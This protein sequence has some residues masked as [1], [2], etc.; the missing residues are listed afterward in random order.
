MYVRL[1]GYMTRIDVLRQHEIN[2]VKGNTTFVPSK[3]M[4]L[5][6]MFPY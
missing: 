2:E 1:A 4:Y 3:R 5:L 6:D